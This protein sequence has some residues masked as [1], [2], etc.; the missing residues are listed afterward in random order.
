MAATVGIDHQHYGGNSSSEV[1]APKLLDTPFF[2][3]GIEKDVSGWGRSF[4][5]AANHGDH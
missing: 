3:S 4:V 5:C 2:L 1:G